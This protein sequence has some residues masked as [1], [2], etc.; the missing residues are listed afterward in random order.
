MN[1]NGA[2]AKETNEVVMREGGKRW[3]EEVPVDKTSFGA[4]VMFPAVGGGREGR[5]EGKGEG[6]IKKNLASTSVSISRK[7][8]EA[9]PWYI[10]R[11]PPRLPGFFESH[12]T[13]V[14]SKS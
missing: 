4:Q 10:R 5:S 2:G 11:H 9:A 8:H 1:I 13:S 14:T 6:R 12:A 3:P 7:H